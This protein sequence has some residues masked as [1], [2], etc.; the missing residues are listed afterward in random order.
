MKNVKAISKK[1]RIAIRRSFARQCFLDIADYDYIGARTLFRN[2]CWDQ[3]LHLAHQSIEKYLKAILL[4]N[5]LDTRKGGHD[6][7]ELLKNV[8][9]IKFVSLEEETK[10]FIKEI[11]SVRFVRYLSAPISGERDYLIKLD[12]AV[13]DLRIFC[14]R[15]DP[16]FI[17]G[18][19][20]NKDKLLKATLRGFNIIF[21][22]CLEKILKN[23]RGKFTTLR[24]NLV[25][26]NFRYGSKKKQ[27]I[28]FSLGGWSKNP[29]FF[30][31]TDAWKKEAFN[32]L[33]KYVSFEKE[34]KNYFENLK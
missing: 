19:I 14:S 25:W 6:L 32:M 5:D 30:L 3:F 24:D 9:S 4:F 26:K 16:R 21:S 20:K 8:N 28:K 33:S 18:V 7:E 23:N 29:Y 11:N 34:V 17:A 31:E 1:E 22:G 15:R 13:W 2:E 27:A 12:K 10:D